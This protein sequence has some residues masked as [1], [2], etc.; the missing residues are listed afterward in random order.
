MDNNI[1]ILKNETY[2]FCAL[3]RR[4][5]TLT[6]ASVDDDSRKFPDSWKLID[7]TSPSWA[8]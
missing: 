2:G 3:Y 1:A 4:H 5:R 6:L 7:V 8:G